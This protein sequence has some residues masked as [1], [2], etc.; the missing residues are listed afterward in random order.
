MKY[1]LFFRYRVSMMSDDRVIALCEQNGIE[2]IGI[3]TVLLAE[4]RQHEGYRCAFASLP[5]L[6][7][8]WNV[9]LEKLQKIVCD[10]R[11]FRLYA[12]DESGR[13]FSSIYLDEE[14]N[15][16]PDTPVRNRI[17]TGTD[18]RESAATGTAVA[19]ATTAGGVKVTVKRAANGRF[20]AARCKKKNIL[21]EKEE[22]LSKLTTKLSSK[23][24]EIENKKRIIEENTDNKYEMQNEINTQD[25]KVDSIIKNVKSKTEELDL[26]ISELD[27]SRL[28]K[29]Q[30]E[31]NF[32]DIE[33]KRNKIK[34]DLSEIE[35]KKIEADNKIKTYE[36]QI[37]QLGQEIRIKESRL[38]FLEETEKEKEGYTK[39]VKSLLKSAE[40]NEELKKGLHDVVANLINVKKEY[41]IAIDLR[42]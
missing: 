36:L 10:F 13:S 41:E 22:E 24:L 20:T 7:R 37:N 35:N 34:N 29:S 8:R 3:Y 15:T 26:T 21:K 27:Q 6:A 25:V 4:L 18:R 32:L 12:E 17:S 42:F 19:G 23:Q 11:L 38:K 28:K 39:S 30:I 31:Q 16:E 9:S 5:A 14:M 1:E 33:N 2:G 40:V